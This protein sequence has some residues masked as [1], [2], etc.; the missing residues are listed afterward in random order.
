[1]GTSCPAPPAA[2][3][4][5]A[6]SRLGDYRL[7]RE[8]GHGG[9]GYVYEAVHVHRGN[10][11][12]LKTLPTLDGAALHRFK[13][14]FRALADVNHP[15]LVRLHTVEADGAQ[16]FFPRPLVE[17]A[18]SPRRVGPGGVLGGPRLRASLTQL[19]TGVMAL[20]ARHIIHRD[21]KPS[22]VLVSHDGRVV[23]LDFG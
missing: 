4:I 16:G 17:G 8:L 7:L 11:V 5:P 14:E 18:P 3:K 13:R 22:N 23:V 6:A 2:G 9:M 1:G 19:V 12:A 21:L 10:R 20:H 15:N